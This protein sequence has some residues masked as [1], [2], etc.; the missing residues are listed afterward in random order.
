LA[1][2]KKIVDRHNG[3]ITVKSTLGEGS[4][5]ILTLPEKQT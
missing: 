5:F 4:K 3:T 1:I 2:C